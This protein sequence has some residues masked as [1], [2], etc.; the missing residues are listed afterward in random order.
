MLAGALLLISP[1]A[2]SDKLVEAVGQAMIVN[3]A[4]N[5]A[6]ERAV[7]DAMRQAMLH[8]EARVDSTASVSNNVLVIESARVNAAGTVENV[9]VL[10][11]WT[12]DELY[13]VRIRAQVPEKKRRKP[14]AAARYRK[15]IAVLQ[16]DVEHR[17]HIHD[18]TNIEQE[19]GRELLRRLEARGGFLGIDAS[20][21]LVSSTRPGL[22]FDDPRVYTSLAEKV[23][24]QV[25]LS[26]IIRDMGVNDGLI[27]DS[28]NIEI[29]IFLHDGLSGARISRH[30]FSEKVAGAAFFDKPQSLF[31]NASFFTT[32][33]GVSLNRILDR[34][35]EMLE[36]DLEQIPFT[37]RI[38][39]I[40][41]R[42][43][44][45]NAGRTSQVAVGDMLMTY[46]LDPQ[47]LSGRSDRFLGY[48]ETPIA[49]LAITQ[50]QPQFAVGE[51]EIESADL[52]AGD[53]VRFG[54]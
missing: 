52:Y 33:F 9:K 39:R 34:Q 17:N 12:E 11:E 46:R 4:N 19:M 31:S 42:K 16:F 7:Q 51:L 2:Y 15:K 43:I 14:S 41:G 37:A 21:Y 32:A 6:R 36:K 24:A 47:A 23:G 22:R 8:A 13:F 38:V 44:Y 48:E 5:M 29:E 35:I 3:G 54:W 26:G 45:F 30:R 1:H 40:Q 18:L 25:I 20:Q 53:L 28:R 50:V 10:Q 49:T 27:Q